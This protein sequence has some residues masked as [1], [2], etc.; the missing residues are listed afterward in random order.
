MGL[1]DT[2]RQEIIER[3]TPIHPEKVILFGSYAYG[4]PNKDSDI[5]LLVVTQDDFIPQNFAEKM[6]VTLPVV[7][8]LDELRRQ[9][10]MDIIVHTRPMHEKFI[11]LRSMFARE[12]LKKG[13]VLYE[14]THAGM[15]EGRS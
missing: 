7:N 10:A 5:D 3:L 6:N 11:A 4:E 15:A 8:M 9:V 12:V 1:D 13:I 14:D 2:L